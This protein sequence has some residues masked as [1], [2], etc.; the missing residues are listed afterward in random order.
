MQTTFRFKKTLEAAAFLLTLSGREMTRYRLV[1]LLYITDREMLSECSNTLTGDQP[2]AR[3]KGPVLQAADDCIL[4]KGRHSDTWQKAIHSD[5]DRLR[6]VAD[7]GNGKLSDYDEAKLSGVFE[8]YADLTDEQLSE[9][10]HE[11]QEWVRRFESGAENRIDWEDV[12][13]ALGQEDM[14][15][16][17]TDNESVYTEFANVFPE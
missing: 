14:I 7:P 10:T 5:G 9:H 15:E 1:K 2:I 4:G 6:L 3:Q 16:A 17:A 13:V 8:R 11:F 12:L